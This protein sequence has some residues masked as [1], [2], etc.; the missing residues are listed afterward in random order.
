MEAFH[1]I[2]EKECLQR[3]EFLTYQ[4]AYET[5]T[6]YLL[7]YNQRRIHG[8]LYNLSPAEFMEA[9][10]LQRVKPFVVKV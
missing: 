8:S 1:G 4:E 3:H 5:V 9:F 10:T 2:L 7:F 6:N